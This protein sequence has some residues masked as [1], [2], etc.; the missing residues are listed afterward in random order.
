MRS[1]VVLVARARPATGLPACSRSNVE[2]LPKLVEV[3]EP[4]L[5]LVPTRNRMGYQINLCAAHL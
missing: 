1:L 3:S 2:P 5:N 4:S